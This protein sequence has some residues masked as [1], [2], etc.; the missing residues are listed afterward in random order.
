MCARA[1]VPLL[2]ALLL[3]GCASPPGGVVEAPLNREVAPSSE[4]GELDC[5]WEWWNLTLESFGLP[6]L[7]VPLAARGLHPWEDVAEVADPWARNL[8]V[9]GNGEASF[10][11]SPA[12]ED[13]PSSYLVDVQPQGGPLMVRSHRMD[14]AAPGMPAEDYLLA[15]WGPEANLTR[16]EALRVHLVGSV[17][18]MVVSYEAASLHCRR[19]ARFELVAPITMDGWVWL[20]GHDRVMCR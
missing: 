20:P 18:S 4:C 19:E 7:S 8:S 17:Q 6:M 12:V 15:R 16:P 14:V 13:K 5:S 11:S 10:L 2:L 3:A 1:L 9:E